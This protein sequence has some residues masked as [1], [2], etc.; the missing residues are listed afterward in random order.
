MTTEG[1][2]VETLTELEA[3]RDWLVGLVK[4]LH[5]TFKTTTG[6]HL[7]AMGPIWHKDSLALA[8]GLDGEIDFWM[9]LLPDVLTVRIDCSLE[10]IVRTFPY[11]NTTVDDISNWVLAASLTHV[12]EGETE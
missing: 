4:P 8:V 10:N 9:E 5:D 6:S 3:R 2:T 1:N 11:P 7:S 12:H